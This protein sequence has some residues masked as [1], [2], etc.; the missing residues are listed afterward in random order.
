MQDRPIRFLIP[1]RTN[2]KWLQLSFST[3]DRSIFDLHLFR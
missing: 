2:R 3:S 1:D